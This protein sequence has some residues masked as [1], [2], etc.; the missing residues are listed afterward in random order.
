MIAETAIEKN[1]KSA[2]KEGGRIVRKIIANEIEA[3]LLSELANISVEH[4]R[5][6]SIEIGLC[7]HVDPPKLIV[8]FA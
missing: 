8:R 1:E 6:D 2:G 4:R 3:K 7:D 5:H